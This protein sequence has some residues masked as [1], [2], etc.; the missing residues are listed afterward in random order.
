MSTMTKSPCDEAF[1]R[2]APDSEGCPPDQERWVLAA[3]VLGSSMAFIDGSVVNIAL[4]VIQQDLSAT[5]AELQW[6]VEAYTL[7]LAAL[8]LVGGSLGDHFGRKRIF[9]LGVTVFS[10]ASVWSGLAPDATQ[11]ILARGLQGIGGALMV[12]GSL[13]LISATFS[14]GKRGQAI[15]TWSGF[16][17][18]TTALGPLLGGWLVD[19]LSWRWVFFINLPI[20]A[21]TMLLLVFRVPESRAEGI[22]EKL[23][24]WGALLA[25]AGLGS[26]TFALV[27]QSNLGFNHP[28]I[29]GGLAG[30]L[31]LMAIF[32]YVEANREAPMMPLSLF[33]SSNFSGAN[34]LTLFLYGALSAALFF[35][36]LNLVQT[37]G[38]SPT[39]AGA[40]LLP[41]TLLLFALS[42]WTGSLVPRFGARPLLIIG[43]AIT[44]GGFALL[45]LPGVGGSYWTTFFPG[46][47]VL[48]LG[49]AFTVAP[50][51]TT[52]M[53]AVEDQNA[54][55]ASGVNNAV[56]RAAGLLTIAIFGIVVLALF[57]DRLD[58]RLQAVDLAPEA[59][60][61]LNL[62]RSRLA[63]A[64]VPDAV[65]RDRREEVG[66]A[67]D[68]AFVF[69]FRGG[70]LAS[71][72]LALASA[73]V[74]ARMIRDDEV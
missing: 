63:G 3:T 22:S 13:A 38:Y 42:R 47:F 56:S 71:A 73:G 46:V 36:P 34:L 26:I 55:V 14:R 6:V 48:G 53:S 61:A 27:E 40:A 25:T 37:Q 31:I 23:D 51:T 33:K 35:L 2:S 57:N 41:F 49:M 45:A 9:G 16:T 28:A 11:L 68:Q 30:G 54:G 4:P 8:M 62:E 39:A 70:M 66:R 72:G 67:I 58:T 60:Q 10:L 59:R 12:P 64:Q 19:N 74:G 32:L 20:A 21:L 29:V 18:M 43:P 7:F 69:A 17:S 1:I 52:V 44:A 65:A 50:L 5:V 15:G 24:W